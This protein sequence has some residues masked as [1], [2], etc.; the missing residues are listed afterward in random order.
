[1]KGFFDKN[2]KSRS[3]DDRFEAALSFSP[4]D[5]FLSLKAFD[6]FLP[7]CL[8]GCGSACLGGEQELAF[9]WF[10]RAVKS[11]NVIRRC[12]FMRSKVC[13]LDFT[14]LILSMKAWTRNSSIKK[15][16]DNIIAWSMF[17]SIGLFAMSKV[18][19][20]GLLKHCRLFY[21]RQGVI[22]KEDLLAVIF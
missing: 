2:I 3:K 17:L 21:V 22:Q 15:H 14:M 20:I 9:T 16:F 18:F 1:M 10:Y 5:A 4:F 12:K 8:V 6:N 13:T 11:Y 19:S 7:H